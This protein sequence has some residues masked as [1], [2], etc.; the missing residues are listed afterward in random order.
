MSC[1]AGYTLYGIKVDGKLL[2]DSGV[3]I[4]APTIAPTGKCSVMA[5][6]RK[7]GTYT[8]NGTRVLVAT[9]T[10]MLTDWDIQKP[11]RI[12]MKKTNR[13]KQVMD[14]VYQLKSKGDTKYR[15]RNLPTAG[16][17]Y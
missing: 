16:V 13:W 3:S 12:V 1:S 2:V 8:C 5:L 10:L 11:E 14:P 9:Q 7:F 6:S 15:D 4:N 17:V